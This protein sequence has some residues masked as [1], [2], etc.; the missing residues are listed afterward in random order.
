[1]TDKLW[2][3]ITSDNLSVIA[4]GLREYMSVRQNQ[5]HKKFAKV[6]ERYY[7]GE[8]DI[9]KSKVY[10][11]DDKNQVIEDSLAT[12]IQITH[13]F[14]MEQVDQKVQ[15]ILSKGVHFNAEN[16]RLQELLDDYM[17]EDFDLF[18][19][20]IVE[21]ASVKGVEFAYVRTNERDEIKFQ[22]SD[23]LN[24]DSIMN[25]LGQVVAV[26]RTYTKYIDD[27]NGQP[28]PVVFAEVYDEKEV[29]FFV[30]KDNKFVLNEAEE[31]NPRPHVVA[32]DP[33]TG[34]LLKR[35]YG[36]IP[37]YRLANNR[38][39]LS[40]LKPIKSLIDDYDRNASYLSNDLEDFGSPIFIVRNAQGETTENIK[41][42]LKL[43]KMIKTQDLPNSNNKQG[44]E[45]VSHQIPIEARRTKLEI[46]KE[47]IYKFGMAFDS[48]QTEGSNLTNVAIQ[49][50]Y[51]LLDLK[52]NKIEPRI[53]GLIRWAL[54]VILDDI[55]RKHGERYDVREI[56]VI[57]ERDTLT[58]ENDKAQR[59]LTEQQAKQTL[60]NTLI[61]ASAWLDDEEILKQ[62]CE[63]LE[64]EYD[65]VVPPSREYL[66]GDRYGEVNGEETTE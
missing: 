36:R 62:I 59:E 32:L 9:L 15:H 54:E 1:M 38:K 50:R 27:D 57:L 34:E 29:K 13:P 41:K 40:D 14:F 44:L 47:M 21:G 16:E 51:S 28:R 37:F 3:K 56:E 52:C 33:E 46:D 53:R 17:D 20:E 48:S 49:S 55:E 11:L 66:T 63:A 43:R 61:T 6:A 10:T 12:N 45:V 39:E 22:V 65:E 60:V 8:H 58:N 31:I 30:E 18:L 23:Y 7:R 19:D 35:D 64:I 24:T 2:Q 5:P 4:D 26:V 25:D 42:Q